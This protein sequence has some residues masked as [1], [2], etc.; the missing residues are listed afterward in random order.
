[1]ETEEANIESLRNFESRRV[2]QLEWLRS[3]ESLAAV[4]RRTLDYPDPEK[5]NLFDKVEHNGVRI[6]GGGHTNVQLKDGSFLRVL[7]ILKHVDTGEMRL[8]GLKFY[9]IGY[10]NPLLSRASDELCL[11]QE[12]DQ[13]S[14]DHP[15][16]QAMTDVRIE[17]AVRERII[18]LTNGK[19]PSSHPTELPDVQEDPDGTRL[20]SERGILKC[21]WKVQRIIQDD[22]K[23]NQRQVV[24]LVV[25]RLREDEADKGHSIKNSELFVNWRKSAKLSNRQYWMADFFCGAG[26]ASAGAREAGSRVVRS[27]DNDEHASLTYCLN[28]GEICVNMDID[29]YC[30]RNGE[31]YVDLAHISP[32]C[33]FLSLMNNNTSTTAGFEN[34]EKN[35]AALF[36]L[37]PLLLKDRPRIVT[38]ENTSGLYTDHPEDMWPMLGQFTALGYSIRFGVLNMADFGVPAKRK[39]FILVGSW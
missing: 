12:I 18:R 24:E 20:I 30:L 9:S 2:D 29:R 23:K 8:K 19:A 32:P 13:D 3:H 4:K 11:F 22:E 38:M 25:A 6:V 26:G 39:R 17:F 28:F 21:R 27:V 10:F 14:K 16:D 35:R 34:N 5:W 36:C 1:M 15:L 37:H 31:R 7:A 33:Q